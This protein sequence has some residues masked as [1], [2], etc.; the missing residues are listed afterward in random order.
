MC[1]GTDNLGWLWLITTNSTDGRFKNETYL[2]R[3][4]IWVR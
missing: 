2:D 4:T 3:A 1:D